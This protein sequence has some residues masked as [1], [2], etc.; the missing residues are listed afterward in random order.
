[1]RQTQV[2][3]GLVHVPVASTT[4]HDGLYVAMRSKRDPININRKRRHLTVRLRKGGMEVF[5][6]EEAISTFP[7][8]HLIAQLMLIV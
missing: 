7:T 6:S 5:R 4:Q 1:M 2:L 8:D 3:A